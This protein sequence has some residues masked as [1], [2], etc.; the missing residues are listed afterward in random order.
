MKY[1]YNR[2][3][4]KELKK[5]F[6][7]EEYVF[8]NFQGSFPAPYSWKDFQLMRAPQIR[9]EITESVCYC[10]YGVEDFDLLYKRLTK[11]K[12]KNPI[13]VTT[14]LSQY[15]DAAFVFTFLYK[16]SEEE[17][18]VYER[19]ME[20]YKREA[21]IFKQ[22]AL[23]R[24]EYNLPESIKAEIKALRLENQKLKSTNRDNY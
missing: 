3:D 6:G 2:N 16:P 15:G 4:P 8:I 21:E 20:I 12:E 14:E 5:I 17:Q 23:L 9:K 18:K 24:D 22:Y 7:D 1:K 19:E 10:V 13:N 11:I